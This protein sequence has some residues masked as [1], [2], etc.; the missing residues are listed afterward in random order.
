[1]VNVNTQVSSSMEHPFG[2]Y[3]LCFISMFSE[4]KME[5]G[6]CSLPSCFSV[7][8]AA[9]VWLQSFTGSQHI[10]SGNVIAGRVSALFTRL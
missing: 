7:V 3:T 9:A 5:C 2:E 6:S 4:E 8:C 1:M 10:Q